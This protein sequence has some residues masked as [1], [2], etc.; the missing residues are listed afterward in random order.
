LLSQRIALDDPE[1][2]P[3]IWIIDVNTGE[4]TNLIPVGM[5]PAW[6]SD[7]SAIR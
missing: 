6:L 5:Q 3:G 2:E 7:T 1:S 4:A